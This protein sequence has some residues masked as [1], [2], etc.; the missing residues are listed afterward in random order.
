MIEKKIK[1]L[2][3]KSIKKYGL[4]D[5]RSLLWTKD[6]QDIRFNALLGENL[7][8]TKMSILDYG[9]GVCDLKDFLTRNQYNMSYNGCDI[10]N[11]FIEKAIER[12]PDEN[13]FQI[14]TS[15]DILDSYDIILVSGTFNPIGIKSHE[16]MEKYVFKNIKKLFQKT[17]YMLTMNFLSHITDKEYKY[18]GHFYLEPIKI[19]QYAIK[20][21]N[22]TRVKIDT[23]S[24]PF[25][26]TIKLYKNSEFDTKN[27]LFLEN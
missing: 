10:N 14:R 18:S 6:K 25:E 27:V 7:K 12:Y 3:T 16:K 19:Y 17:N 9:C 23:S 15:N 2:Y 26:I 5:R 1:K 11:N 22:T 24:L 8:S 4:D 20:E 21:L 13:I